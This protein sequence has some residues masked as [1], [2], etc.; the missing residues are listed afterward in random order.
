MVDILMTGVYALILFGVGFAF[1][2]VYV[3]VR[4]R[5][6]AELDSV[7]MIKPPRQYQDDDGRSDFRPELRERAERRRAQEATR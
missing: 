6:Q 2:G 7:L 4:K 3:Q 5:H 1:G